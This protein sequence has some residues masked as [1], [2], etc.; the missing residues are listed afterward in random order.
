[1]RNLTSLREPENVIMHSVSQFEDT[2]TGRDKG[3]S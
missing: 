2:G 3:N 1:M